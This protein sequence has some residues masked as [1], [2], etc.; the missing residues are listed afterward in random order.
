MR[1]IRL[2]VIGKRIFYIRYHKNFSLDYRV[3]VALE[4][5]VDLLLWVGVAA[6]SGVYQFPA[7]VVGRV[8]HHW[9]MNEFSLL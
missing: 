8:R 5:V 7:R 1:K 2:I 6:G 9:E 3:T 4:M